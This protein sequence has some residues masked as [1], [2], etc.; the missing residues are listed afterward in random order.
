MRHA[1]HTIRPF[2]KKKQVYS[3]WLLSGSIGKSNEDTETACLNHPPTETSPTLIQ[4]QQ[5]NGCRGLRWWVF[6]KGR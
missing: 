6:K 1:E 5:I 3:L 2:K 4:S